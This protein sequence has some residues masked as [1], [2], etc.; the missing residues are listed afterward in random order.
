MRLAVV[1]ACALAVPTTASA[2]ECLARAEA[3]QLQQRDSLTAREKGGFVALFAGLGLRIIAFDYS[4]EDPVA[5]DRA[6]T[7]KEWVTTLR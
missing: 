5:G 6:D 1:V 4:R 3:L 7:R 2:Q